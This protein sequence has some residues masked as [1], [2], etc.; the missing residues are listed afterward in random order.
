MHLRRILSLVAA[1]LAILAMSGCGSSTAGSGI[2]DRFGTSPD[3]VIT[4]LVTGMQWKTGPDRNFTWN[5]AWHWVDGLEGNWRIPLYQ[6]LME[7]WDAGV[8]SDYWGPFENS[9]IYVWCLD[10]ESE[11]GYTEFCFSRIDPFGQG[12]FMSGARVF[13]VMAPEDGWTMARAEVSGS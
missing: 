1:V 4:D 8:S 6:E 12:H 3:G 5:E 11:R 2:G 9:G 10:R 13:A 7:L